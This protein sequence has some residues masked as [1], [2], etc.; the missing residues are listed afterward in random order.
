[1]FVAAGSRFREDEGCLEAQDVHCM[2]LLLFA[3]WSICSSDKEAGAHS[4]LKVG[5][6]HASYCRAELR[7]AYWLLHGGARV[8][9]AAFIAEHSAASA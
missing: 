7:A 8:V 4:K 2:L 3:R 9:P 5:E 1:V 6:V